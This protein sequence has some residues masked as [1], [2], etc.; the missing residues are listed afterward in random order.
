[1]GRW[2]M[3]RA[4]GFREGITCLRELVLSNWVSGSCPGGAA[5]VG[6]A[7][8]RRAN[9]LAGRPPVRGRAAGRDGCRSSLFPKDPCFKPIPVEFV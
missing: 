5:V 4:K 7:S 8:R 9:L 6:T 1:M 3:L 2:S